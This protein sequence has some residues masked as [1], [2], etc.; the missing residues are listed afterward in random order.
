MFFADSWTSRSGAAIVLPIGGGSRVSLPA[1]KF[2][3]DS[4]YEDAEVVEH[5]AAHAVQ[6][7]KIALTR[8]PKKHVFN[9]SLVFV[10]GVYLARAVLAM[11][12]YTA[13]HMRGTA[14]RWANLRLSGGATESHLWETSGGANVHWHTMISD[15]NEAASHPHFRAGFERCHALQLFSVTINDEDWNENFGASF[16]GSIQRAK[17]EQS[18]PATP[19]KFS[20][21]LVVESVV[22]SLKQL[23]PG[24]YSRILSMG[25]KAF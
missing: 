8:M 15:A 12:T 25:P 14:H 21:S 6:F 22:S 10:G 19:S 13:E 7:Y 3:Q 2:S 23:I 20:G 1:K 16:P 18:P 9:G 11:V 24:Q 5:F 4:F 17:E